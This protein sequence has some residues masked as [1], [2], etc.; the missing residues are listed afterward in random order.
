VAQLVTDLRAK[1]KRFAREI[2]IGLRSAQTMRALT[3][4]RSDKGQNELLLAADAQRLALWQRWLSRISRQPRLVL[5]KTPVCGP[6]QLTFR[7]HNFAPAVQKVAVDQMEAD[8]AWCELVSR[9]TIEFDARAA[10]PHTRIVRH[11]SV[12]VEHADAK[13]RLRVAG[14]GQVR[15]SDLSLTNGVRSIRLLLPKQVRTLGTR[16]PKA[17]LPNLAATGPHSFL[18][19]DRD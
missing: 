2:R 3:R 8:G 6:W 4:A 5:E 1:V 19:L 16:P 11:F 18:V 15:V 10:R 7:V 13:L 17:G 12:P 14:V 9:Y